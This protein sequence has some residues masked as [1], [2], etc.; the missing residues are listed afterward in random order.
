MVK[1]EQLRDEVIGIR[2]VYNDNGNV[3]EIIAASGKVLVDCRKLESVLK[4][5]LRSYGFELQVQRKLVRG[6][7]GRETLLPFY[8]P[9]RRVFI[10]VKMRKAIARDS[11]Y[12]YFDINGLDGLEAAGDNKWWL[13]LKN[14]VK[15]EMFCSRST[16]IQSEDTGR[17]LLQVLEKEEGEQEDDNGSIVEISLSLGR[18]MDKMSRQLD[19]IEQGVFRT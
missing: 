7:L 5:L 13:H 9:S 14:G 8:L 2:P 12:G 17:H 3:T 19:R 4:A 1:V 11:V 16:Y 15:L 10:P 18:F 6:W